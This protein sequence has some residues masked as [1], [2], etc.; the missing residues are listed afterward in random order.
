MTTMSALRAQLA[1]IVR[2]RTNTVSTLEAISLDLR[3]LQQKVEVLDQQLR[4]VS[5]DVEVGHASLRERQLDEFDRVRAAVATTTDDLSTRI[6][7][8][9]ARLSGSR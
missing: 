1:W 6:A 5:R 9:D 4:A 2:G 8:L 3:A 7:A